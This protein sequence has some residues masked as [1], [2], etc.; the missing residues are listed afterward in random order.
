MQTRFGSDHQMCPYCGS[1]EVHRTVYHGL[2]ERCILGLWGIS[3]LQCRCCC[4]RFYRLIV[5]QTSVNPRTSDC[6]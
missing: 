6:A 1:G 4:K 2:V 5:S 3:P